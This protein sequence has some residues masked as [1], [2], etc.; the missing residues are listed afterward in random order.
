MGETNTNIDVTTG[1][2]G[3]NEPTGKT[4]PTVEELMKELA[5]EKAMNKKY[6]ASLDKATGEAADYKRQLN[7][8]MSADEQ[9]Q[10]EALE[11]QR[12]TEEELNQLRR[13]SALNKA[14]KKFMALSMDEATATKAAEALYDGD[15]DNLFKLLENHITSV[16]AGEEQK[17]LANRTPISSGNSS[18]QT[19]TQKQFDAMSYTELAQLKA[20]NP[21]LYE[22]LSK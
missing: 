13:E 20:E 15:T 7:A 17:F 4:G 16:K 2:E 8:K 18:A 9:A 5:A 19:I 12:Q 6:K 11:R 1:A 3:N 14:S 22:Q 21:S 10:A